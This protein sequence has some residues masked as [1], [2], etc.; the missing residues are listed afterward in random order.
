[1]FKHHILINR[2]HITY[3]NFFFSLKSKRKEKTRH[4]S[5][6]FEPIEMYV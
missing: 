6:R 4:W 3:G 5:T 2:L 1:M